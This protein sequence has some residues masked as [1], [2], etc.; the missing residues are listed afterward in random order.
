MLDQLF[1]NSPS[2]K[3]HTVSTDENTPFQSTAVKQTVTH[4][5]AAQRGGVETEDE[6][7]KTPDSRI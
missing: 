2:I 6:C 4:C 1:P 3:S 5:T 7:R